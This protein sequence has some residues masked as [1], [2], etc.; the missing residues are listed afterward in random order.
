MT[1]LQPNVDL[2]LT[3]VTGLGL[4]TIGITQRVSLM[5]GD[6]TS[7]ITQRYVSMKLSVIV[8]LYTFFCH[9]TIAYFSFGN[10]IK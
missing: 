9:K 1:T 5:D 4:E 8:C 10:Y 6:W 3:S 7:E 2:T